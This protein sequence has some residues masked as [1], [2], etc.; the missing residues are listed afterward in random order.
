M[1]Q[2]LLGIEVVDEDSED[3]EKAL[4]LGLRLT[5]PQA[6]RLLGVNELARVEN[7]YF[8]CARRANVLDGVIVD[9]VGEFHIERLFQCQKEALVPSAT[10]IDALELHA[11]RIRSNILPAVSGNVCSHYGGA[12]QEPPNATLR[13]GN[14]SVL[15][16]NAVLHQRQ[17]QQ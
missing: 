14:L 4:P 16:R 8:E 10:A 13:L 17:H 12:A 5:A 1:P 7:C 11:S 3:L 2:L 6:L 9:L 15:Q